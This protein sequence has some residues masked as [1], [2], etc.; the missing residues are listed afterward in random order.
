MISLEQNINMLLKLSQIEWFLIKL[1]FDRKIAM[2]ILRHVCHECFF[3]KFLLLNGE[4]AMRMLLNIMMASD[5]TY[6]SAA[7]FLNGLLIFEW[8][9]QKRVQAFSWKGPPA[10]KCRH[11]ATKPKYWPFL[12]RHAPNMHVNELT[13]IFDHFGNTLWFEK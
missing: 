2:K 10:Q 9:S 6:Q 13:E 5:G 4:Q 8:S 12:L 11:H 1:A 7:C 3:R